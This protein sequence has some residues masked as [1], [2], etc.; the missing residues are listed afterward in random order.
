M[1]YFSVED[2]SI[3]IAPDQMK[4]IFEPFVQI[5]GSLNREQEGTGLWTVNQNHRFSLNKNSGI[6]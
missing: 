3:G 1:V 4:N 5:E 2:T 6:L